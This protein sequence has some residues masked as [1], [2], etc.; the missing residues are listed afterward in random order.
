MVRPAL[1]AGAALGAGLLLIPAAIVVRG[2]IHPRNEFG[3]F[4]MIAVL[5]TA[6]YDGVPSKQ[7]A[8]RLRWAAKLWEEN[9][10]QPVITL[11]GS[12]PGDRFTEA[13]VGREYLLAAHVDA[14]L[15]HELPVGNDSRGSLQA[16]AHTFPHSSFLIVT[17]PNH[18]LRAELIAR[19]LGL[20]AKA[21]GTP[22]TPTRFPGRHWLLTLMHECG[23]MAVVIS[24]RFLGDRLAAVV[25]DLLREG[26]IRL[27]PSR[28][29]RIDYIRRT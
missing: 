21:S 19:Q 23:G 16:L 18:A 25:E 15:V 26:E 17:D 13:Q 8:A 3:R 20:D 4:D 11:G 24:R 1:V 7:L 10:C 9:R 22:F 27:R 5:G 29:T 14:S 6:Q 12:L 28:G 2:A